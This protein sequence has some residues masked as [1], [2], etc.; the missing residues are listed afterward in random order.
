MAIEELSFEKSCLKIVFSFSGDWKLNLNAVKKYMPIHID[1][2]LQNESGMNNA[3]FFGR[4][5]EF[6]ILHP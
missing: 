1:F 2:K 4:Q 6:G 5:K 3:G